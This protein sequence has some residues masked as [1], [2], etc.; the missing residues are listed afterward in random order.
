M[1]WNAVV[2]PAYYFEAVGYDPLKQPKSSLI[3]EVA[4]RI[5]ALAA[6][7]FYVYQILLCSVVAAVDISLAYCSLSRGVV[8]QAAIPNVV[9]SSRNLISSLLEIPQKIIFGPHMSPNYCG[10]ELRYERMNQL[11]EI[12][13]LL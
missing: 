9:Y 3:K 2:Y 8:L 7:I 10:D 1:N 6:P 5:I 11:G 12:F 4:A 13:L